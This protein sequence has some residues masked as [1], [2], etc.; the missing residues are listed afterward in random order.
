MHARLLG[1]I[2]LAGALA[3][4]S[5]AAADTTITGGPLNVKGYA[6]TVIGND[7]GAKD[8]LTVF[9]NKTVG[10]DMQQH[11]YSFDSGVT[12][13]PTSIKAD[14]GKYGKLDLKLTGAKKGSSAVPK[15]CTGKAGKTLTGTLA[16][17]LKFVADTTYF[18]TIKAKS[19]KGQSFKAGKID[20]SGDNGQ[21]GHTPGQAGGVTLTLTGDLNGDMLSFTAAKG[22]QTAMVMEEASKT[23]PAS[24]MHF[25]TA[26]A[27]ASDLDVSDDLSSATVKGQEP[28]LTGTGNF[29][30]E[31]FG[32]SATG[33]LSGDLVARFDS[34]GNVSLTG[35]D[36]M[37]TLFKH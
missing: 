8:S 29:E 28:F 12:V 18:K 31:G 23:A 15:G 17:S 7:A 26:E 36:L 19:L 14:L 21:G 10:K 32:T 30:G 1:G 3:L 37:A 33:T 25:I 16:G 35:D 5:A 4:P 13:G 27:A 34:I 20:C 6:M 9:F 22:F 2:A 11:M 24:I